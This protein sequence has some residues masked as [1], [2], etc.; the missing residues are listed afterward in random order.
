MASKLAA[1]GPASMEPASEE[2]ADPEAA[3]R[4]EAD[5]NPTR[6]ADGEVRPSARLADDVREFC[7]RK[8]IEDEVHATIRLARVHFAIVG[9]P[10]FRVV[11]DPDCGEYY[12]GIHVRAEGRPEHVFRQ[13]EAFLDSFLESIDPHKQ[14]FINL[15]YH[16]T[17]G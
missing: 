16:S 9:E 13:S 14:R 6:P 7:A 12:V 17:Q 2:P 10:V 5:R 3:T 15:I 1:G 4:C 8:Q 11:N